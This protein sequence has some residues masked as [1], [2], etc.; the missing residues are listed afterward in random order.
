MKVAFL[1]TGLMGVPMAQRL[2]AANIPLIAYNRTPE[3]LEPLKAAG[4]ETVERPHQAIRAADCIIL[5]LT[6]AMAIYHVLLSDGS[7]SNLV[8]RTVIQMGTITPT[9]SKEI[10]NAVVTAGAQY[11][12]AP[13]LGSIPE[14]EAGK[15]TV[16]VGAY[17]EQYQR[18]L[19]LLKNFGPDPIY[20]GPVGTAAA[21]KLALNQLIASLT[22]SFALS[23]GFVQRQGIDVDLFMQILRESALYAPT[24]DK[25]LQRMLDGNYGNPNFPTKHLMKDTDL[26]IT[27]A[28]SVDLNVS[29]IEGVQQV[30]EAA[31]KMSLANADYSSLFCAINSDSMS[32]EE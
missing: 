10:R 13:V 7:S 19:N 22:T 30:L 18:Y 26:F 16:M 28:K 14:A 21:L 17:P 4:A 6:N 31:I 9:E 20:V 27:E 24:F 12:E 25:K 32:L 11:I 8:G 23:L 29:S 2:L 15:L 5:M 1:G 3:K